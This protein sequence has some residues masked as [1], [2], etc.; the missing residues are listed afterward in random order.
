[1]SSPIYNHILVLSLE[2]RTMIMKEFVGQYLSQN[3]FLLQVGQQ[4]VGQ[5]AVPGVGLG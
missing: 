5:T 3:C 2:I 1:M 4:T